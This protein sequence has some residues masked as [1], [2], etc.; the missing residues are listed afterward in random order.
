MDP[1]RH[2]EG[3]AEA[4]ELGNESNDDRSHAA[5]GLDHDEHD[6]QDRQWRALCRLGST[7][8]GTEAATGRRRYSR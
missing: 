3:G 6:V 4:H 5:L 2:R 1:P 7:L 8:L